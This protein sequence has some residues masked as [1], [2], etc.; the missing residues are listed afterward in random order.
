VKKKR[1]YVRDKGNKNK[2]KGLTGKRGRQAMGT[3]QEKKTEQFTF[4]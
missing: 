2:E 3:N 1:E 4:N